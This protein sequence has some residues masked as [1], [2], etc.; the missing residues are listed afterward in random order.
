MENKTREEYLVRT[1]AYLEGGEPAPPPLNSANIR[2][3]ADCLA[4][5]FEIWSVDSR[6][7]H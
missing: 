7:N 2:P 5:K 4:W 1:G 6:E 3:N